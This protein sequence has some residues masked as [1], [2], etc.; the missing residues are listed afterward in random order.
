MLPEF[1]PAGRGASRAL[2]A[3]S[4][5]PAPTGG[6]LGG[7][8]SLISASA[9]LTCEGDR[10]WLC[11]SLSE[12]KKKTTARKPEKHP[13]GELRAEGNKSQFNTTQR[14]PP[15]SCSELAQHRFK[16]GN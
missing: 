4:R 7:L 13:E 10:G 8:G 5:G 15:P 14:G 3:K 12:K 6:S 11:D 16:Y 2:T 9:S 1:S